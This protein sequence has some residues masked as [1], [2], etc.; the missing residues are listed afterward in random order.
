MAVDESQALAL[1]K[2]RL[3]RPA[4]DTSLDAYFTARVS[5]AVEKLNAMM[6]EKLTDSVADLMLVVD[7]AVW[8]YQDRD[9]NA[10]DPAW[11]RQRLR[12]RHL[13]RGGGAS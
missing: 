6:P 5:A 3:N 10:G 12:E 7:Y 4:A 9:K 8:Q 13:Q 11:L 1:M 2:T